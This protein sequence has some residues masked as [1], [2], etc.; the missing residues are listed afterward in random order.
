M[1]LVINAATLC[2]DPDK[3]LVQVPHGSENFPG[4]LP[5]KDSAGPGS[6]SKFSKSGRNIY[7]FFAD[8]EVAF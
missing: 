4:Y 6:L 1:L 3:F 2:T 5:G 8:P 7:D